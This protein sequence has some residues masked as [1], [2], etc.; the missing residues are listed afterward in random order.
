MTIQVSDEFDHSMLKKIPD[1]R[2]E[3]PNGDEI[4]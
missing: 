1:E 4:D 3:G 2:L